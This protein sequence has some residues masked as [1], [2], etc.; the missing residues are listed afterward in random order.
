M[1]ACAPLLLLL[2]PYDDPYIPRT[3][4]HLLKWKFPHMNSVDFKLDAKPSRFASQGQHCS[5]CACIFHM[6]MHTYHMICAHSCIAAASSS[7]ADNKVPGTNRTAL[8][9][10]QQLDGRVVCCADTGTT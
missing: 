10:Q 8:L 6:H 1:H 3:Y 4:P 5:P 7:L 2:Q 9:H